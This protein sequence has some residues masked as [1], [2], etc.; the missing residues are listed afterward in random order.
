MDT[1]ETNTIDELAEEI[2]CK[3]A[4]GNSIKQLP[5]LLLGYHG[6]D[7]KKYKKFC[8]KGYTRNVAFRNDKFEILVLCWNKGQSSPVR[9]HPEKGCLVRLLKG[10]LIEE[11]YVKDG[12]K[13]IKTC[14][15]HITPG[16]T[17]YQEGTDG[18]HRIINPNKEE[19]AVTMHVYSPPNY[20]P[21]C[22]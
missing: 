13:M 17:S 8:C 16:N 19:C 20:Y 22:Y 6:E 15:N 1:F 5:G 12:D 2:N 14:A 21:K 9:D 18:L 11:C 7:W 4:E 3:L 10:E